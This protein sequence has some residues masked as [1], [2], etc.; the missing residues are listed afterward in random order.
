MENS[1]SLIFALQIVYGCHLFVLLFVKGEWILKAED[2]VATIEGLESNN[3]VLELEWKCPGRRG[4]SPVPT[5]NHQQ[6]ILQEL[7]YVFSLRGSKNFFL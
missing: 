1:F 3:K 4:P 6:E 2:L 7:K 5:N